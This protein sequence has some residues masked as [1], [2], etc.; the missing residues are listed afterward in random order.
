MEMTMTA[1]TFTSREFSRNVARAKKATRAGPVF[2]TERGRPAHV[3]LA[4]EDFRQ[5]SGTR[6]NLVEALSM[7]ELAETDFDSPR[8][9]LDIRVPELS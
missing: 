6:R 2:I 5:L 4:V 9:R 1:T 8:L 7:P 3:L